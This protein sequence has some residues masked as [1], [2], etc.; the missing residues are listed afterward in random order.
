[1]VANSTVLILKIKEER[2][3]E[4]MSNNLSVGLFEYRKLSKSGS[5]S[6]IYLQKARTWRGTLHP[7]EQINGNTVWVC[8]LL[9]V[10]HKLA[11]CSLPCMWLL[12]FLPYCD[13]AWWPGQTLFL[14][15]GNPDLRTHNPRKFL[16]VVIYALSGILL[17]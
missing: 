13:T 10:C 12:V 4:N 16:L 17:Q 8:L 1:M 7:H 15:S 9:L 5:H 11:P 2:R 14:A 6:G 3:W